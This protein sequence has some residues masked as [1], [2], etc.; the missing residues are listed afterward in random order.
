M[1]SGIYKITNIIDG[2]IYI[3]SAVNI[4]VRWRNHRNELNRNDHKNE[5]LQRAW[6]KYK[7]ENFKFEIIEEVE[8]ENNLLE[9]EQYW[10]DYTESFNR[11]KGYNLTPTAGSMLGYRFSEESKKKIGKSNKG[12]KR[13]EEFKQEV[14]KRFKG[15]KFSDTHREKISQSLKQNSYWYGKTMPKEIKAKMSESQ[16]KRTGINSSNYGKKFSEET[17]RKMSEVKKGKKLSEDTK[18]KMSESHK[19]KVRSEEHKR[20]LSESVKKYAQENINANAKVTVD[21]VRLIRYLYE[22]EKKKIKE[23]MEITNVTRNIINGIISYR[24]WK[25]I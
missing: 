21:Q 7:E 14:S 16:K 1:Q 20:K 24:T 17:K 13:S 18:K 10:L 3:G 25:N 23:I 11:D 4:T 22:S 8:K 15:K 9:R 12:K 5:Y 6:N 2:K 19:G